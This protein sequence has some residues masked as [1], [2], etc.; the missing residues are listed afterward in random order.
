MLRDENKKQKEG[1]LL[2]N[3]SLQR[4]LKMVSNLKAK[5][6]SVAMTGVMVVGMAVPALAADAPTLTIKGSYSGE[7]SATPVVSYSYNWDEDLSFTYSAGSKGTWNPQTHTYSGA[8]DAGTWTSNGNSN[9]T[10]TNHSNVP[11]KVNI[12]WKANS[13]FENVKFGVT[14]YGATIATAEGTAVA[15]APK[16]TFKIGPTQDSAGL[17]AGTNNAA[18]GTLTLNVASA[19]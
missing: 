8:S 3:K 9:I 13:G 19:S 11:V 4:I 10:V 14:T 16:Q 12:G 15:D 17:P 1:E 7:S 5:L 6:L 2:P 18:I